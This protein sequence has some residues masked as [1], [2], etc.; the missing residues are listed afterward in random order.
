[1]NCI[2]IADIDKSFNN[3]VSSMKVYKT[4]SGVTKGM[5][6]QIATTNGLN[7]DL[8]IGFQSTN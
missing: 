4:D 5:W 1:M 7:I 6:R 3:K 8:E 2:E